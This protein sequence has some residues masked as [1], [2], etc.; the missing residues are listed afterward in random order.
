MEFGPFLLQTT[1]V[2]FVG[3][4]TQWEARCHKLLRSLCCEADLG[5]KVVAGTR[6]VTF[7]AVAAEG[8]LVVLA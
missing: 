1:S 8:T 5:T 3:Q 6:Q 2:D 7:V 4:F